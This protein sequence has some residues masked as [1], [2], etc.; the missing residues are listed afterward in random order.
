MPLLLAIGGVPASGKSWL[1]DAIAAASGLGVIRSDVVRK[2]MIGLAPHERAG[3]AAYAPRR[4]LETYARLGRLAA[5]ELRRQRGAIVDAT[6]RRAADRA[7]FLD[8]LGPAGAPVLV[9]CIAPAHV[10]AARARTRALDPDRF[11]DADQALVE[12][13]RRSWQ[14]PDEIA[15][16]RHFVIRTDRPVDQTLA[17]VEAM[18]DH[19]LASGG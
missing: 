7:A 8:A 12:R 19:R 1:A 14:P 6:F 9:E 13:E 5:S 3:A 15:P 16:A 17:A 18:L 10:L 11:S 4:S 2:G